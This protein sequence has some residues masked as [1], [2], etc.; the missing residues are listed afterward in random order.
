VIEDREIWACAC[1]LLRQYG[2]GAAFHAAQRADEL[3]EIA[4]V[5]GQRVWMRILDHIEALETT[6]PAALRH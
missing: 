6:D 4:D 1:Q 3:L 5:E 2:D